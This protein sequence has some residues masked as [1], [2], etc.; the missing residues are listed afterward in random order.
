MQMIPSLV[1]LVVPL[2]LLLMVLLS[3]GWYVLA[4][5]AS[6]GWISKRLLR[7]TERRVRTV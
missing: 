3:L 7:A 2:L 6:V 1:L 5:L 4:V